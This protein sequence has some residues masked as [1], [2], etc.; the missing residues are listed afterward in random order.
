MKDHAYR[1]QFETAIKQEIEYVFSKSIKSSRDCIDLCNEIYLRTQNKINVN[2]LRR[3]FGLVKADYPPSHST[4]KIL[5]KYCGFNSID[6]LYKLKQKDNKPENIEQERMLSYIVS[7][8]LETPVN[9]SAD[10][11]FLNFVRHTIQF[12]NRDTVL[13][14][15]YLNL[16]VKT[17]N[18]QDYFFQHFVN[19]DK[20]NSYYG[21]CIRCY[22]N[23]KRNMEG[24]IFGNS[25]LAYKYWLS[26]NDEG[27]IHL[28]EILYLHQ[29]IINPLPY[30]VYSRYYA[31]RLFYTNVSSVS[32]GNILIEINKF[33]ISP[34]F[35]NSKSEDLIHFEYIISEALVLTGHYRDA[36]RYLGQYRNNYTSTENINYI[37]NQNNFKLL[38]SLAYYKINEIKTAEKIFD[39]IKPSDFHFLSKK[40]SNILY[41]TLTGVLKRKNIKA[42]ENRDALIEETGFNRLKKLL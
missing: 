19:V 22:L 20:L 1:H 29:P 4:L 5:S 2:T 7:L 8:F 26:N 33:Y 16:I 21:D 25:L 36:L 9:D 15:K 41:L 24:Y 23:E 6:E 32:A 12:L 17:K 11:T 27:L 38:E 42:S 34:G 13:A 10:K 14:D 18:G 31:A 39:E 40:F 30:A 3:F 35:N 28:S 37:L